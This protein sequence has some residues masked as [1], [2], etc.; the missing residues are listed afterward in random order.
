MA[1]MDE[2]NSMDLYVRDR[3]PVL[4]ERLR[5]H[6]RRPL[7]APPLTEAQ[8]WELYAAA[9]WLCGSIEPR[10]DPFSCQDCAG[11]SEDDPCES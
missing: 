10:E 2:Y 3:W 6:A 1:A 11:K 4:K 7:N 8:S 5:Q 9:C